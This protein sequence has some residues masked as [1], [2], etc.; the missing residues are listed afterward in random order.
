M[1][2]HYQTYKSRIALPSTAAK[3]NILSSSDATSIQ[4]AERTGLTAVDDRSNTLSSSSTP[5][6]IN[7]VHSRNSFSNIDHRLTNQSL[8]T[9]PVSGVQEFQ[10]PSTNVYQN[11]DYMNDH[12]SVWATTNSIP[13]Q[14]QHNL[15][16]NVV[17]SRGVNNMNNSQQTIIQHHNVLHN[18]QNASHGGP[19]GQPHQLMTHS[20]MPWVA[21]QVAQAAAVNNFQHGHSDASLLNN[22][23]AVDTVLI[24]HHVPIQNI[25][26]FSLANQANGHYH[27]NPNNLSLPVSTDYN[28]ALSLLQRQ[29]AQQQAQQ[30]AHVQ[31]AMNDVNN[32]IQ[33]SNTEQQ[34]QQ[35]MY[36]QQAAEL[37]ARQ[38]AH[39]QQQRRHG[40][41]GHQHQF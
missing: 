12:M 13:G 10:Q 15:W 20:T 8:S 32:T 23:S 33:M 30:Q 19:Q 1:K 9:T 34:A 26:L 21:A 37:E 5:T 25:N 17:G 3:Q 38:A 35:L 22:P 39:Q 7:D 24:S 27:Q 2:N 18:V 4:N 31:Q 41:Q 6:S 29:Q 16:T 28:R 40:H 11:N 14:Q 36:L